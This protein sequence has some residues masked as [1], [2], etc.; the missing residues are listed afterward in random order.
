MRSV[1][2]LIERSLVQIQAGEKSSVA[3]A[4]RALKPF[5]SL[6]PRAYYEFLA[7]AVVSGYFELGFDAERQSPLAV[8]AR[9]F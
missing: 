3:Q 7:G 2:T 8:V 1:S 9:S 5:S 4:G 6:I